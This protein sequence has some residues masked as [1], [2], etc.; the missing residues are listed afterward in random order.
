MVDDSVVE[1]LVETLEVEKGEFFR[2]STEAKAEAKAEAEEIADKVDEAVEKL[3][4][5][6]LSRLLRLYV[7][8]SLKELRL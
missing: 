8:K 1:L 4:N 5:P 6:G 3:K 7:I 2:Q